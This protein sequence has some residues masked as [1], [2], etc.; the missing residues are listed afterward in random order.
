MGFWKQRTIPFRPSTTIRQFRS[1]NAHN[2][3]RNRKNGTNK[4]PTSCQAVHACGRLA[5][6]QL[7]HQLIRPHAPARL[8][9]KNAG[10]MRSCCKPTL[11][12]SLEVQRNL[13]KGR[14]PGLAVV[15]AN[16]KFTMTYY[17]FNTCN[18]NHRKCTP[19][20][21]ICCHHWSLNPF[22]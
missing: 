4:N 5:P 8:P 1:M 9:G 15:N 3:N 14:V 2:T 19:P 17:R 13:R 18:Q 22:Q 16:W 6:T 10:Q 12:G 7:S 20:R 21:D 11:S